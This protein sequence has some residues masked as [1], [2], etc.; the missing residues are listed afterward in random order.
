M[1]EIPTTAGA[2]SDIHEALSETNKLIDAAQKYLNESEDPSDFEPRRYEVMETLDESIEN[3]YMGRAV[4]VTGYYLLA[5]RS[6]DNPLSIDQFFVEGMDT[7]WSQGFVV[8]DMDKDLVPASDTDIEEQIVREKIVNQAYRSYGRYAV[9]HLIIREKPYDINPNPLLSS[10]F[11]VTNRIVAPCASTFLSVDIDDSEYPSYVRLAA[12]ERMT[13]LFSKR[14]RENLEDIARELLN[15]QDPVESLV[16]VSSQ[17]DNLINN[18]DNPHDIKAA[19][20][21]VKALIEDAIAGAVYLFDDPPRVLTLDDSDNAVIAEIDDYSGYPIVL[22]SIN[23][24]VAYYASKDRQRVRDV[25]G[26]RMLYLVASLI[27]HP[28]ARPKEIWIPI[29]QLKP[30]SFKRDT[31]FD[32]K[33]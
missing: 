18:F 20:Q 23:T 9:C 1:I 29:N 10:T 4:N 33:S 24:S 6:Q 30:G 32:I 27:V 2:L 16:K 28:M 17:F 3:V 15:G 8:A 13:K 21:Y 5:C 12:V 11:T 26:R 19:Y 7:G 14:H 31:R 25:P 22:R